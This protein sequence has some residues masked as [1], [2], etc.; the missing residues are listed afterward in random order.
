[1]ILGSIYFKSKGGRC[2]GRVEWLGA[3][4]LSSSHT[5]N[6]PINDKIFSIHGLGRLALRLMDHVLLPASPI[7]IPDVGEH[8]M[9]LESLMMEQLRI[10]SLRWLLHQLLT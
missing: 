7:I 4:D 8:V 6:P 10:L 3:R 2:D 1:M 9:L 5:A